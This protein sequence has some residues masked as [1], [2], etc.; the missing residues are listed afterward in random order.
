MSKNKD[1][2]TKIESLHKMVES[3][4]GG[5]TKDASKHLHDYLQVTARSI[6]FEKNNEEDMD[7]VDVDDEDI[8]DKDVDDDDVDDEDKD[9][10]VDDEDKD[11]DV[12]DDDDDDDDVD[13]DDDDVDDEDE[14][15]CK[16]CGKNP[17]KCK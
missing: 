12:D 2:E 17:C 7:D 9:V 10:D 4:I 8:E 14:D 16:E 11:V 15:V 6:I 1:H 5:D 13:V 3:V